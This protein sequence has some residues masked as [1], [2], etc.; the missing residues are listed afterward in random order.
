MT[1]LRLTIPVLLQF[2]K[3][4]QNGHPFARADY[5]LVSKERRVKPMSESEARK[6]TSEI[7]VSKEKH[8]SLLYVAKLRKAWMA[9]GYENFGEYVQAEF[10]IKR[11]Q[12]YNIIKAYELKIEIEE[13]LGE[14]KMPSVGS[15]AFAGVGR[16]DAENVAKDIKKA[17]KGGNLDSQTA[18]DVL[19]SHSKR[20]KA[21]SPPPPSPEPEPF[22]PVRKDDLP[23]QFTTLWDS[24]T[25]LEEATSEVSLYS[26]FDVILQAYDRL[27]DLLNK[28]E[29]NAEDFLSRHPEIADED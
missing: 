4:D 23:E 14:V 27:F 9:L 20:A 2:G 8:W 12:A 19:K 28:L 21:P 17:S 26:G 22:V 29:E 18:K 25:M 11:A 6:L 24:I 1:R 13:Y 10:S 15:T 16:D 7:D 5:P 3:K